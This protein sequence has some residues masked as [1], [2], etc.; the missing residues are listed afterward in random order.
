MFSIAFLQ[1]LSE[2]LA[3]VTPCISAIRSPLFPLIRNGDFPSYPSWTLPLTSSFSLYFV[4]IFGHHC[5]KIG[6]FL[7]SQFW[8]DFRNLLLFHQ[9]IF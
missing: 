5:I 6:H 7:S 1:Q 4:F 2:L 9:L 8:V 3:W